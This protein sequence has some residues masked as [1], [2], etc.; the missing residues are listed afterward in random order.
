MA[1]TK[2]FKITQNNQYPQDINLNAGEY[3]FSAWVR[4]DNITYKFGFRKLNN[5]LI[6]FDVSDQ[7][8]FQQWAKVR[9]TFQLTEQVKEFSLMSSGANAF[10]VC[11][12]L[13]SINLP[14]SLTSIGSSAFYYCTSLSLVTSL[15][16]VPPPLGDDAFN[17][18]HT[19]L[20]IKVP[21][22][23]VNAYKAATNWWNYANKISAI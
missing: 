16:T 1:K 7:L 3:T 18:T 15:P 10:M 2:A 17:E 6:E 19:N 21:S 8:V 22:Q 12:S 14:D 20:I 13:T 23:S 4:A 9:L 11:E 5:Q